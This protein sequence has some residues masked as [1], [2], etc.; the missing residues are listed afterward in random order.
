M[1]LAKDW[2]NCRD[3]LCDSVHICVYCSC[4]CSRNPVNLSDLAIFLSHFQ[5]ELRE[6]YQFDLLMVEHVLAE[7]V[8]KLRPKLNNISLFLLSLVKV[9]FLEQSQW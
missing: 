8:L 9:T 1:R 2:L 5:T 4:F 7:N 6:Y 3:F